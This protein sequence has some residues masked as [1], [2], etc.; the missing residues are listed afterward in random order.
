M[1]STGLNAGSSRST[2]GLLKA[3]KLLPGRMGRRAFGQT[4]VSL[5][6]GLATVPLAARGV[7][8]DEE[9]RYFTWAG[10]ELPEFHQSY[11]DKHGVSPNF[12]YFAS[13]NEAMQRIRA[14]YHTDVSHPCSD[15]VTPWYEAGIFA[16]ID[17]SRLEHWE[18]YFSAFTTIDETLTPE[19]EN[20]FIPF[21]WGNSSILYRTDLVDIEEESWSLLFDERYEGKLVTYNAPYPGVQVLA[22]IL[23][24]ENLETL[25]DAQLEE[26]R[27]LLVK[28]RKLLRFYWDSQSGAGQA[29]AAGEIVA[30]YAWNSLVK[31]VRDEGLAVKFMTCRS[32]KPHRPQ[33]SWHFSPLPTTVCY[34]KTIVMILVAFVHEIVLSRA[35]LQLEN[36]ALRQQVAVLK[37]AGKTTAAASPPRPRVLGLAI[38]PVATLEGRPCHRQARDG[39]R[40]APRGFRLFWKWKSCH[41]KPGRPRTSKEIRELIQRM[42]RENP[43]WGAPRNHGELLKLGIDVSQATVT[44]YMV[45]HP[46]PPSQTWRTFLDNHVGSLVSIDF[47]VV[48]TARFAVL[49]VFIVLRHERRRIEHFGVTAHPSADWVAQQMREAFPWDTAPRYLIRDRDGAYGKSFRSTI[50][51]MGAKE[52]VTAPRRPWQNP[53]VERLI[54]SVRRECLNHVIIL[55]ERH[56]RRVLVS[57]LDYYHRSRTHLSLGKD[58]PEGRPVQPGGSGKIVSFPQVGR[59]HHRYERLAA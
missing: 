10:Y 58:T 23:G 50:M 26:I 24:Y 25:T 59:L 55:N 22:M 3:D 5:G 34:M 13:V 11:I 28:Q 49:F 38:S 44:R 35:T 9:A 54:G 30:T 27:K 52:V 20:L 41:G 31:P 37:R 43:L 29:M 18:D 6:L 19:G 1:R 8:A 17:T 4:V 21:E 40:L 36:V 33:K 46:K 2:P 42:S 45:R 56:L 51:A 48:P 57:Y 39:H 53:Y 15:N 47:F 12:G 14:G 16:P 7:L 32:S